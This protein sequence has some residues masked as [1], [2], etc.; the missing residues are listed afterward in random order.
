MSCMYMYVS[1]YVSHGV[2][3]LHNPIKFLQEVWTLDFR[4]SFR[5]L[6]RIKLVKSSD[7]RKKNT[8]LILSIPPGK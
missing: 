8:Y 2:P 6:E 5:Q 7:S 1:M 3:S 4:Q